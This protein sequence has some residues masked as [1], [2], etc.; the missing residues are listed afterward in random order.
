MIISHERGHET[1]WD[2]TVW[3]YL[4]NDDLCEEWGGYARACIGCGEMPTPEGY[5]ACLGRI[6][7]MVSVCCGHGV[8]EPYSVA[9]GEVV[10]LPVDDTP[11]SHGCEGEEFSIA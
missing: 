4:D 6:E 3:R 9:Q 10:N 1:Y 7:G 8:H 5:D 11:C 2:G